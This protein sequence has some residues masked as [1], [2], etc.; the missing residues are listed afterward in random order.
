MHIIFK[1]PVIE[2]SCDCNSCHFCTCLEY[3]TITNP[4]LVPDT[5]KNVQRTLIAGTDMIE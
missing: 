5:I 3:E 4:P 2:C 1:F